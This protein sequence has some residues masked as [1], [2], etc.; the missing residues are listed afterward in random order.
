VAFE[1]AAET[2][3]W[4]GGDDAAV[5]GAPYFRLLDLP[6]LPGREDDGR[7]LAVVAADPWRAMQVHAGPSSGALTLRGAVAASATVGVL[8]TPLAPGV[9]HRWDEANVIEGRIEG[10]SPEGLSDGAVLEGGQ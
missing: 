5:G 4:R 1:A 9:R 7:P 8:T 2:L 10:R 6:P 3:D